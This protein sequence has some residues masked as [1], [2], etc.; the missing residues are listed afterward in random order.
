MGSKQR[1]IDHRSTTHVLPDT[2]AKVQHHPTIPKE[3]VSA[4]LRSTAEVHSAAADSMGSEYLVVEA[5]LQ[6]LFDWLGGRCF[7]QY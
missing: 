7:G 4:F 5:L 3:A 6:C 2:L 1:I